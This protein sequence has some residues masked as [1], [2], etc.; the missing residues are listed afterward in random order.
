MPNTMATDPLTMTWLSVTDESGRRRVE[1]RWTSA[2]S[3]DAAL[4]EP[5]ST[6][7]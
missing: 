4:D 5:T 6:A 2:A 3:L 7:A 1:V